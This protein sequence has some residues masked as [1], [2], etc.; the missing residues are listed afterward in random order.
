MTKGL[1]HHIRNAWKKPDI[2]VLRQRMI[3]WRESNTIVK[4]D[5]P[6]RLDRAHS[7]GYKAKKGC[8]HSTRS[9]FLP[10]K[11]YL[12]FLIFKTSRQ[13][14]YLKSRHRRQ[15]YTQ[16]K[17]KYFHL[18]QL[19]LLRIRRTLFHPRLPLIW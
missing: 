7:L 6:L 12:L 16:H 4:V 10:L 19:Q 3:A 14:L 15:A 13:F 5:K 11:Q 1:Y 8:E 17:E 9:L 2:N 18:G